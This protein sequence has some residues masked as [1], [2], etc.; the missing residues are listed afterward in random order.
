M[1]AGTNFGGALNVPAGLSGVVEIAAGYTTNCV[2][3]PV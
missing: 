2:R 1:P 3:V